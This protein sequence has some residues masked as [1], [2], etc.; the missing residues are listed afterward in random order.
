[1]DVTRALRA[2]RDAGVEVRR[3]EL[4]RDGKI[5]LIMKEDPEHSAPDATPSDSTPI[6]L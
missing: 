1:M 2:A 6:V 3:T 5:V 4:H